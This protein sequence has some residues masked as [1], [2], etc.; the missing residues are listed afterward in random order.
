VIARRDLNSNYAANLQTGPQGQVYAVWLL[1]D[2]AGTA[3]GFTKSLDGGESFA[4]AT[5]IIRRLNPLPVLGTSKNMRVNSFPSM[6]VD[7]SGAP[8]DGNIYVVWSNVGA[9]HQNAEKDI[10]VYMIK[11]TDEGAT[12]SAPVRVNQDPAGQGKQQFFPWIACDSETGALC[13][14]F[15]DDRNVSATECEVFVAVSLDAGN[16]WEDFKV[17]DVAFTPQ[18]ISIRSYFGDYLGI[19]VRAGRVYPC[20]TDNR[21]GPTPTTTFVS[22]FTLITTSVSRDVTETAPE[23]FL[24]YQ[25]YP[26]PFNAAT[27]IA[28]HLRRPGHVEMTIHNTSGQEV[29][30]LANEYQTAGRQEIV[31]DGRNHHGD[32]LGTGVYVCRIR[33][34]E[35][36]K[37]VKMVLLK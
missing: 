8:S 9:P 18:P 34:G 24:L 21:N 26:N 1:T 30:T 4:P 10:D 7:I 28:Y 16:T 20:W 27:T 15:Y 22:P 6:T 13:V 33:A 31:W 5:Q 19:A 29:N 37:S 35:F 25:N 32:A 12:W 36:E 17:S 11:S 14:I 23:D 3:L 2:T